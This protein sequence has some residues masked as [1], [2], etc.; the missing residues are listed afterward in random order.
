MMDQADV[1]A[2][3][4]AAALAGNYSLALELRELSSQP[5]CAHCASTVQT[6]EVFLC[7]ACWPNFKAWVPLVQ[8]LRIGGG[9]TRPPKSE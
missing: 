2:A 8:I 6:L 1:V 5:L 4:Q 9:V 7:W 3:I